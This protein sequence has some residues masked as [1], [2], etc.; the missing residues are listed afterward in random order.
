MESL[1]GQVRDEEL[2][3]HVG[4][5]VPP[6]TRTNLAGDDLSIWTMVEEGLRQSGA[7]IAL[8]EPEEFA[9][10]IADGIEAEKFWIETDPDSDERYM[11]GRVAGSMA[12]MRALVD[13]KATAMTEHLPPDEYLW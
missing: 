9:H 7:D 2:P 11:G 3:V 4:V 5:V 8:I 6:L 13:A 10:V 12:R 1:Y